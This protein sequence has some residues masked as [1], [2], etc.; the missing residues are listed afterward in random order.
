MASY[1]QMKWRRKNL[2]QAENVL[3][4]VNYLLIKNNII[5]NYFT[6]MGLRGRI[7]TK[8]YGCQNDI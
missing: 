5:I 8:K 3:I 7:L 2:L 1:V 6:S 4:D